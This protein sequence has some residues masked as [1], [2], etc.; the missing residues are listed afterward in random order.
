MLIMHT[1]PDLMNEMWCCGGVTQP[2]SWLLRSGKHTHAAQPWLPTAKRTSEYSSRHNERKAFGSFFILIFSLFL[3]Q[4]LNRQH[5]SAFTRS[6]IELTGHP[7]C[8]LVN[9]FLASSMDPWCDWDLFRLGVCVC[10]LVRHN[11]MHVQWR[12]KSVV[13]FCQCKL[14]VRMIL[15]LWPEAA[16][17]MMGDRVL[18]ATAGRIA[19]C[20]L[21]AERSPSCAVPELGPRLSEEKRRADSSEENSFRRFARCPPPIWLPISGVNT[22]AC[23]AKVQPPET[24]A[25]LKT[26]MLWMI[27]LLH[28]KNTSWQIKPCQFWDLFWKRRFY[29]Y[30]VSVKGF[31]N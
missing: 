14:S 11:K 6:K 7:N 19:F 12:G 26:S 13:F 31:K 10:V 29:G 23:H 4:E 24:L 27:H 9:C 8:I 5:H 15:S 22:A 18:A 1:R 30:N 28:R 3:F 2:E 17:R 25:L 20:N 16:S 21:T